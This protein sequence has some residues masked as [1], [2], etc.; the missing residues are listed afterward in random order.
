MDGMGVPT[1]ATLIRDIMVTDGMDLITIII[2]GMDPIIRT[3]TTGRII[4]TIMDGVETTGAGVVPEDPVEARGVLPEPAIVISITRLQ[5][6][7]VRDWTET[8]QGERM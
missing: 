4:I 7:L 8:K 3:G 2:P 1:G 5:T 6:V